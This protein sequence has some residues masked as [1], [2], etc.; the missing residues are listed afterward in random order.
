M[1]IVPNNLKETQSKFTLIKA[2]VLTIHIR[3][4]QKKQSGKELAAVISDL[5]NVFAD[6]FAKSELDRTLLAR[7][8]KESD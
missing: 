6:I 8:E 7:S 5:G 2:Q 4:Y 1:E 3:L